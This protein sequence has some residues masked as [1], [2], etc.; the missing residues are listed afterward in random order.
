MRPASFRTD[1][2]DVGGAQND[3][4]SAQGDG[5]VSPERGIN[6][7]RET[8]NESVGIVDQTKVERGKEQRGQKEKD[9]EHIGGNLFIEDDD[10]D[11]AEKKK[12]QSHECADVEMQR[13]DHVR[14]F[15]YDRASEDR[16][17]A[18]NIGVIRCVVRLRFQTDG[19]E[20]QC[21]EN[22]QNSRQSD[23]QR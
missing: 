7:R 6:V 17:K 15:R 21:E 5:N 10:Q 22:R 23:D 8:G 11:R 18:E 4:Q 3:E 19:R 14:A 2:V 13:A 1:D 16:S 9:S 20:N 12:E